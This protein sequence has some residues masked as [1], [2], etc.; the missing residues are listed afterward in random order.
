MSAEDLIKQH[1]DD[2]C[3]YC[4]L[5]YCD[6]IRVTIDRKTKCDRDEKKR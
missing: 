6:G 2:K 1:Y 4:D 5:Q 3:K